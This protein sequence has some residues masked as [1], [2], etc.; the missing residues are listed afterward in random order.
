MKEKASGFLDFKT[1]FLNRCVCVSYSRQALLLHCF[2]EAANKS[3]R[4]LAEATPGVLQTTEYLKGLG[5]V[6]M[7]TKNKEFQ[8]E[9]QLFSATGY[10]LHQRMFIMS[11]VFQGAVDRTGGLLQYPGRRVIIR[12]HGTL[13]SH[14]SLT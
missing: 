10:F 8:A 6:D 4:L 5:I 9:E 3:M 1:E 13:D 2:R 14:H 7:N 11:V 12:C